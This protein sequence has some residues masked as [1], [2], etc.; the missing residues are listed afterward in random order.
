MFDREKFKKAILYLISKYPDKKLKGKKK[1]AKLLYFADFDFFEL[2]EKPLTGATYRVMSMGPLPDELD[3]SLK[4]I[5]NK[6][7]RVEKKTIGYE[8]DLNIYS[9]KKEKIDFGLFSE[10]EKEI[11]DSVFK[12]YGSLSGGELE[13]ISHSEASFNAVDFGERIPYEL[14]FYRGK[15]EKEIKI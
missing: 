5:E 13:K 11:L 15:E 10:K 9:L 8:N 4:E 7:L 2:Y 14:A 6:Q 1:L 3:Q 12:R